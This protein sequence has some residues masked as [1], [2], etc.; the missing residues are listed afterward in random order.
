MKI[1]KMIFESIE[2]IHIPHKDAPQIPI[3]SVFATR[4]P[5]R[6]NKIGLSLVRLLNIQDYVFHFEDIDILDQ[7]FL[8]DIKP[9]IQRYDSRDHTRSGWHDLISDEIAFT[10]GSREGHPNQ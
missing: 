6:P 8:L 2:I 9:Y 5:H 1:E 4:A 7:T 10:L 3:Q